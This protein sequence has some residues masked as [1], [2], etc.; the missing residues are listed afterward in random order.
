MDKSILRPFEHYWDTEVLKYWRAHLDQ[1]ITKARFGSICTPAY[2]KA[3]SI[4]NICNGFRA[5]RIY[6]FDLDAIP[7]IAFAPSTVTLQEQS[8]TSY[9]NKEIAT[10]LQLST[11]SLL[12]NEEMATSSQPSTSSLLPNEETATRS[13]PNTSSLY[14]NEEM[15]TSSQQSTSSLPN[16]EMASN[17]L[18]CQQASTSYRW[19]D[20]VYLCTAASQQLTSSSRFYI[21][22]G[23]ANLKALTHCNFTVSNF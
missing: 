16:E 17:S 22:L 9:P 12:P 2:N 18:I 15:A 4:T 11:S 19:I 7:D 3:L 1:M 20:E 8:P 14:P 10:I 6:P 23:L 5:T 13:Q 21:F